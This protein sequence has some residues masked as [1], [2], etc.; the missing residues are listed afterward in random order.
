MAT[1]V[2]IITMPKVNELKQT[3]INSWAFVLSNVLK[4]V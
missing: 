4:I 3:P 1:L 2:K